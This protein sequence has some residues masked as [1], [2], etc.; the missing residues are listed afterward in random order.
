M[1][2]LEPIDVTLKNSHTFWR[3]VSRNLMTNRDGVQPIYLWGETG[4]KIGKFFISLSEEEGKRYFQLEG[5]EPPM[6]AEGVLAKDIDVW[7]VHPGGI[8]RLEL[9]P[10]TP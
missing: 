6:L 4:A 9:D 7:E 1:R 5:F 10:T 8:Y 2:E 3:D